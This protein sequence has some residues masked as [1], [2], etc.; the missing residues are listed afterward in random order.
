MNQQL[1]VLFVS[2]DSSFPVCQ[3]L[4]RNYS[5][6]ELPIWALLLT[7]GWRAE[8]FGGSICDCTVDALAA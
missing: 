8:G 5:A 6:I 2:P 3:V 4:S 7:Q 1:D